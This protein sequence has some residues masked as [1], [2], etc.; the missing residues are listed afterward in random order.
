MSKSRFSG[1]VVSSLMVLLAVRYIGLGEIVS[2]FSRVSPWILLV[3]GLTTQTA[4]ICN[5]FRWIRL[6]DGVPSDHLGYYFKSLSFNFFT[7]SALGS[8]GFRLA[9]LKSRQYQTKFILISLFRERF[10]GLY[11][12]II[13][14][15]ISAFLVRPYIDK[16]S[17]FKT[18]NTATI[19]L[20]SIIIC[21]ALGLSLLFT[22]TT[23]RTNS[24]R[25]NLKHNRPSP[26]SLLTHCV[27]IAHY[28]AFDNDLVL[29]LLTLV[30]HVCWALAVY[31]VCSSLNH[32]I[33]LSVILYAILLT[34]FSRLIPLSIQGLGIREVVFA[35]V[36]S[37]FGYETHVMYA[38][39]GICY[40]M[41]AMMQC[42]NWPIGSFATLSYSQKSNER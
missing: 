17:E 30:G 18:L 38:A 41:L 10:I 29:Q 34:E 36:L 4:F 23:R 28:A 40:I 8:D 16:G 6:I 3:G 25:C 5:A 33:S 1:I 27:D 20:C 42:L 9:I 21:A 35:Y 32:E 7:P 13:L 24:H 37:G 14:L 12:S 19:V 15:F 26:R 2:T 11:G 22:K 39:G 31:L